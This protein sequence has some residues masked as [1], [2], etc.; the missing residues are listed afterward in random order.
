MLLLMVT[1]KT[2]DSTDVWSVEEWSKLMF[3][4]A[5]SVLISL[6]NWF[7]KIYKFDKTVNSTGFFLLA[8]KL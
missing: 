5:S 2:A 1:P 8:H 7:E 4:N 6:L 3:V